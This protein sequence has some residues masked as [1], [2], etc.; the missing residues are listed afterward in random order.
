ME[1]TMKEGGFMQPNIM[2]IMS[3]QQRRNFMA[4]YGNRY[5]HTPN[6]DKLAEK[7]TVSPKRRL[8]HKSY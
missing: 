4:T 8:F 5:V 3:D 7:A 1:K 6:L 2:F